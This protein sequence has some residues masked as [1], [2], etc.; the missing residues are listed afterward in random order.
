M[1]L[2][3][4]NKIINVRFVVVILFLAI[5]TKKVPK[6]Y[7]SLTVLIYGRGKSSYGF[8]DKLL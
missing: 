6:E 5:I 8:I 2:K 7:K 3:G 4:T 1:G